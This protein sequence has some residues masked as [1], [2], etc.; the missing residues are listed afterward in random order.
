MTDTKRWIGDVRQVSPPELW[1]DVE[2]RVALGEIGP[3]KDRRRPIRAVALLVVALAVVGS[4]LYALRDLGSG[5]GVGTPGP[6]EIVRYRLDGAPQPLAVGEGAAWVDVTTVSSRG[7]GPSM[8]WRIDAKTGEAKPLPATTGAVWVTTG[9][10]AVWATCNP[11]DGCGGPA[12][13]QLDP[14]TGE[15]VRTI[16]LPDRAW[17]IAAGL[18]SVWVTTDGGL[19]KIDAGTEAV[20]ATFAGAYD[21]IGTGGGS[22]WA[23]T[24]RALV[25]IDPA[26]GERLREVPFLDPCQL[27]ATS[28][29]VFVSSCEGAVRQDDEL[30]AID[31]Q[32]GDVLYRVP[33]D[34]WGQMRLVDRTLWVAQND[35]ANQAFIRLVPLDAGSGAP[36]G[37]PF[38][39]QRDETRFPIRMSFPPT[40]FFSVGEGSAWFTDFSAG[41]VIRVD[42]PITGTGM[43]T[44]SPSPTAP[45][46]TSPAPM[47]LQA[48]SWRVTRFGSGGT[49]VAPV[50]GHE[51]TAMFSADGRVSG[52]TGCN[53]YGADFETGDGGSIS[54]TYWLQTQ[55]ACGPE[56]ATFVSAMTSATTYRLD[57]STLFLSDG[58]GAFIVFEG[59][60][61]SPEPTPS[62]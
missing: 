15:L 27:E 21:L 37:P 51:P 56:E 24:G 38:E 20:L 47:S 46:P 40:V 30:L 1:A 10:G 43:A 13:L 22:V 36:A 19:V 55:V 5:A 26:S 29:V 14:T 12:V 32:T 58:S 31:A 49:W 41:E 11:D 8:I 53:S 7:T 6:G 25:Q 34:G 42:L 33:M 54:I 45:S 16:V 60:A 28:E 50:E 4:A 35:P 9:E 59:S 48:T 61:P 57:G 44:P 52:S 18:G 2:R 3:E 17:Q 62:R 39:V 23:T